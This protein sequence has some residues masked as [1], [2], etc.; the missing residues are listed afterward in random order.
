MG[1]RSV[2][3]SQ[4]A[5]A[6][7]LDLSI[8]RPAVACYI[9]WCFIEDPS[10]LWISS[11]SKKNSDDL[12]MVSFGGQMESSHIKIV[13]GINVR[14]RVQQSLDDLCGSFCGGSVKGGFVLPFDVNFS[15]CC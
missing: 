15:T 13:H 8:L 7:K 1:T 11:C 14:S 5:K 4:V 2:V 6:L 9:K 12:R 10:P 3:N